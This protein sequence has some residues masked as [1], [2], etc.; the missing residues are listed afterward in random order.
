MAYNAKD[1]ALAVGI[2]ERNGGMTAQALAE[3]RAILNAPQ[4]STETLHRWWGEAGSAGKSKTKIKTE[5]P[6][7]VSTRPITPELMQEAEVALDDLFETVA[8]RYLQHALDSKALERLGG[9]DAVTA[10]AIAVDKMR[11]IRGL[12]TAIVEIMPVVVKLHEALESA[13]LNP[14]DVFERMI[15]R[16]QAERAAVSADHDHD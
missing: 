8:R 1:K 16:V 11:L 7:P 4:L 3:I 5:K 10:A 6:A 15:Q 12:P 13:G 14:A 2:L 9:K